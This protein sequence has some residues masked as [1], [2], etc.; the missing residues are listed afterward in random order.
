MILNLKVMI[1]DTRRWQNCY[2]I[3]MHY[4]IVYVAPTLIFLPQQNTEL[5]CT[6]K[7]NFVRYRQQSVQK[8]CTKQTLSA[9]HLCNSFDHR[10]KIYIKKN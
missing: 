7:T 3:D 6:W 1:S 9:L 2:A 10:E 4:D 8:H 5:Y